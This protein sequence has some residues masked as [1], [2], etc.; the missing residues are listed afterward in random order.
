MPPPVNL[1]TYRYGGNSL[2]S[3]QY[4]DFAENP[5]T[6]ASTSMNEAGFIEIGEALGHATK[7]TQKWSLEELKVLFVIKRFTEVERTVVPAL[8]NQYFPNRTKPFEEIMASAQFSFCKK[9]PTPRT[10]PIWKSVFD[11]SSFRDPPIEI[12]EILNKLQK[13]ATKAKIPYRRK[14]REDAAPR[15]TIQQRQRTVNH[16]A[17]YVRRTAS[18]HHRTASSVTRRQQVINHRRSASVL[19]TR[20]DFLPLEEDGVQQNSFD[21]RVYIT[22]D[23]D[24]ETDAG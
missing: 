3:S 23:D 20:T 9:R 13:C 2:E 19:S 5:A 16:S 14:S 18:Y 7:P 21:S 1:A 12:V 17:T 15:R 10:E 8:M 6:N 11:Q 24:D 22:I 4:P